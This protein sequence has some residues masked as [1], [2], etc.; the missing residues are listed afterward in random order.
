MLVNCL[1]IFLLAL[2]AL[3]TLAQADFRPGYVVLSA[4][5]TLR[6]EVD[7]RGTH[8]NTTTCRFRAARGQ[9]V[10][11]LAPTE[12]VAYGVAGHRYLVVRRPQLAFVEEVLSGPLPLW[13]RVDSA[14]NEH[15]YLPPASGQTVAEELL[16][17][18]QR[19]VRDGQLLTRYDEAFQRQ[20]ASR[21]DALA[22]ACVPTAQQAAA[23]R[24]TYG[25]LRKTLMTYARCRQ[26][27]F[28]VAPATRV[29]L[30]ALGGGLGLRYAGFVPAVGVE[31][32]FSPERLTTRG[33]LVLAGTM[34]LS[35]ATF[36]ANYSTQNS[37]RMVR[38]QVRFGY[39][40]LLGRRFFAH[41]PRLRSFAEA[42]V[43]V[44]RVAIA[45]QEV[46]LPD[47]IRNYNDRFTAPTLAL[48]MGLDAG[49]LR[50]IAR[51]T[52]LFAGFDVGLPSLSLLAGLRLGHR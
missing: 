6:G 47:E 37:P 34:S 12:L 16:R 13:F 21:M 32:Q 3:P 11:N 45:T 1:I 49:R 8:F 38:D 14:S 46:K 33:A 9:V 24:L 40:L 25:G 43:G 18:M 44:T 30:S 27:P 7:Q 52:T 10:R 51:A 2:T 31:L 39:C 50:V 42:G 23:W 26:Q 22:P 28:W 19:L 48:G 4:G 5:D 15:Y 36:Q 35:R 20:L 41:A 29:S 17:P